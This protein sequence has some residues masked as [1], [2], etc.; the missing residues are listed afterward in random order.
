MVETPAPAV[1]TTTVE[2]MVETPAPAVATTTEE[3]PAPTAE[4]P[5]PAVET[6]TPAVVTP[7][8]ETPAVGNTIAETSAVENTTPQTPMGAHFSFGDAVQTSSM[9]DSGFT[10]PNSTDNVFTFNMSKPENNTDI[11]PNKEP[12]QPTEPSQEQLL[13]QYNNLRIELAKLEQQLIA[14]GVVLTPEAGRAPQPKED[15]NTPPLPNNGGKEIIFTGP[16]L[17]GKEAVAIGTQGIAGLIIGRKTVTFKRNGSTKKG[18]ANGDTF[19]MIDENGNI[20]GR[21]HSGNEVQKV[22]EKYYTPETAAKNK[23]MRKFLKKAEENGDVVQM[24]IF[25][26]QLEG[27]KC[28]A[29]ID[30]TGQPIGR[31]TSKGAWEK[32]LENKKNISNDDKTIETPIEKTAEEAVAVPPVVPQ[33]QEETVVAPVVP[34]MQEETAEVAKASTLTAE[35]QKTVNNIINPV[36]SPNTIEENIK[37]DMLQSAG[38]DNTA[39]GGVRNILAGLSK[40]NF[41]QKGKTNDVVTPKKGTQDK[42]AFYTPILNKKGNNH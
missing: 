24:E 3:Q 34:P 15:E 7:T 41:L 29:Y 28:L 31:E 20:I 5:A 17:E 1:A 12:A 23:E 19:S 27:R 25:A 37:K 16:Q 10:I 11:Q 21:T 40:L 39:K 13:G 9:A 22:Y 33:V 32:S 14:M 30:G 6:A 8:P 38:A 4:I 35:E 18:K 42:Q 2:P 26:I 36:Q